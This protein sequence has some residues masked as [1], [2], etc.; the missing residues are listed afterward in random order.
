MS[1]EPPFLKKNSKFMRTYVAKFRQFKFIWLGTQ[2]MRSGLGPYNWWNTT[3]SVNLKIYP[4]D[5]DKI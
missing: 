3:G 5:Q 4:D 2:L 1:S